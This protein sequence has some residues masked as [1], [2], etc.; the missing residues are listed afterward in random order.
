MSKGP[1]QNFRGTVEERFAKA[2]IPEPNSG[3]W[4]WTGSLSNGY[5]VIKR[6]GER[7]NTLATHLSLEMVGRP[8]PAGLFACHRCNN[9]GCVNPDHVYHGTT[10]QNSADAVLAGVMGRGGP[11]IAGELNKGAKLTEEAVR[12]IRERHGRG[13]FQKDLAVEFSVGK[14]TIGNVVR[15]ATWASVL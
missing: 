10:K 8:L 15:R 4:L 14:T 5:G 9:K 2:W 7:R 11:K 1:A 6:Q 13:I 12:L 3:C